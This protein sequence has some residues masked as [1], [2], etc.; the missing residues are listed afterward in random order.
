M[1][2][3]YVLKSYA[4]VMYIVP[5]ISKGQRGMSYLMQRATR[6]ARDGN[7]DIKQRVRHIGNK[8]LNHV[9][10]SAQRVVYLV[11][12]MSLR[13]ARQQFVFFNIS[14][15]EERTVLLKPFECYPRATRRLH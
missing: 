5:Y 4:C 2:I 10:L 11:L 15:P 3:Q 6:E 1:D 9:E 13:K 12:Q 14:L 7:H 8:F